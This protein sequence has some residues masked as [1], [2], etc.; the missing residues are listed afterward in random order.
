[1]AEKIQTVGIYTLGCKVN[2]YES[3][4]IA[5]ELLKNGLSIESP[6]EPCDAYI[7]NTCTVTAES[8]RKARQFIRRAIS[9][10]P[11]AYV[12]VTGCFAQVSPESIAAIDG[13]DAVIGNGNKLDAA[14]AI[15]DMIISQKAKSSHT[16]YRK[17]RFACLT[18][19]TT[20]THSHS[21]TMLRSTPQ[22]QSLHR[23]ET[24]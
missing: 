19:S 3:E 11:D 18:E 16:T 13:V 7:I 23:T 12:V 4:A 9:K 21:Y 15:V 17:R 2:Q 24:L 8:D 1:M 22:S 20:A 10:N 6:S 5:E 14:K